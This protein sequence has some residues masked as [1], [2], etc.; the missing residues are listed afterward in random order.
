MVT[1]EETEDPRS[2]VRKKTYVCPSCN[3]FVHFWAYSV[4]T[5][6]GCGKAIPNIFAIYTSGRA[7]LQYHFDGKVKRHIYDYS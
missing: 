7:R 5:C 6:R 2:G 4:T 1:I 3:C